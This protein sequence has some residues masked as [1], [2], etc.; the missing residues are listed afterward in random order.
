MDRAGVENLLREHKLK[1]T[2]TRVEVMMLLK[3]THLHPSAEMIMAKLQEQGMSLSFA[4]VYNILETFY[5]N[6]LIGRMK[7][8]NNVM[9]FDAN[10]NFHIHL[11]DENTHEITD[12][13]D[14]D[15]TNIFKKK[16]KKLRDENIDAKSVT[17]LINV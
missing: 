12:Y 13:F 10:T 1:V 14:E 16:V 8:E 3:N 7:D 2:K 5:K 17:V 15:L 9:R 6:G 4:S 11:V